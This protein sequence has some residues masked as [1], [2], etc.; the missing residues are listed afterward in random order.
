MT[1][2]GGVVSGFYNR[3][4]ISTTLTPPAATWVGTGVLTSNFVDNGATPPTGNLAVSSTSSGAVA[5]G[6]SIINAAG[7]IIALV[8]SSAGGANWNVTSC[9]FTTGTI[10]MSG[11]PD[12]T[13]TLQSAVDSCPANQVV[14]LNAGIFIVGTAG[15]TELLIS[16]S[17]ITLRGAGA[18][19]TFIKKPNGGWPRNT[20]TVSGTNGIKANFGQP[21][22]LDPFPC[23]L[24]APSQFPG[25]DDVDCQNLTVDGI[26]GSN[27]IT[28]DGSSSW[29]W[30]V[31]QFVLLDEFSVA[32]WQPTPPNFGCSG[33][34][35][36]TPCPPLV[37]QSD[38]VTWNI[39]Y[40][41]QI[42]Q[43]DA[44]LSDANAPL[45]QAF[46]FNI[47]SIV[48]TALTTTGSP[49]LVPGQ[50][51]AGNDG[52]N[53]IKPDTHI[54]SGAGNSWVVDV[55]QSP[56]IGPITGA[57]AGLSFNFSIT[58]I[59]GSTMTTSG[60]PPVQLG[61]RFFGPG[62]LPGSF[63]LQGSGNSWKIAPAQNVGAITA[64][65]YICLGASFG[66]GRPGRPWAEVKEVIGVNGNTLT[67]SSP[68]ASDYRVNA[69]AQLCPYSPTYLG[70][71]SVH[72]KFIGIEDL[73]LVGGANGNLRFACSAYCWAQNVEA[74]L[75][76]NEN[77]AIT[78]SFRTEIRDSYSHTASQPTPCG[79]GYSFSHSNG[80]AESLIENNVILDANKMMVF[81]SAGVG[82][83]VGYN[84]ADNGWISYNTTYT[85]VG[86]NA[87]HL[88]GSHMVLFEGNISF[89]TDSDYTHGSSSY[90]LHFRN[91][92][93]GQRR[94]MTDGILRCVGCGSWTG[95][96]TYIGNVLGYSSKPSWISSFGVSATT[97][98]NGWVITDPSMGCTSG[99]R[100]IGAS[101]GL[102]FQQGDI[103]GIGYDPERFFQAPDTLSLGT[104][105]RDGNYD[106]VTGQ[107]NFFN[108]PGG[109]PIPDSLYLNQKPWF[110]STYGSPSGT[111]PIVNPATGAGNMN[112]ALYRYNNGTPNAP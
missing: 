89:N 25:V 90:T 24:V 7:D 102:W 75:W 66:Y 4:T 1:S 92:Y 98:G 70:R 59:V 31:G 40:P 101:S 8:T 67:F 71:N 11:L 52:T 21:P 28:V 27:Q 109:F 86:L 61:T 48:G 83:V 18:G 15:N 93:T 12:S 60:S 79:G 97:S 10:A 47:T 39:H 72:V 112:P 91:W 33:G 87:S 104:M 54:V 2:K 76:L 88:V 55:S 35:T 110:F 111:W 43:D 6:Q 36:A 82:T 42:F 37:W 107:Q 74:T 14:K 84:Y 50:L 16:T 81:R 44:S 26:R 64:K 106:F 94:D 5:V 41:I 95:Y 17:N 32:S 62:V 34:V 103:F 73:T 20:T 99:N 63:I 51:I 68:L 9:Y 77:F 58:S 29:S 100:C 23:I 22:G 53:S 96:Q 49:A 85:E 69:G 3:T 108:T 78:D 57:A 38:R 56:S 105:I 13:A 19:V 45:D 80:S 30:A 46:T 65:G